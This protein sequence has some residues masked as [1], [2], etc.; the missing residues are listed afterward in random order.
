[1]IF[2]IILNRIIKFNNKYISF[3]LIEHTHIVAQLENNK[4]NEFDN[5]SIDQFHFK[6]SIEN[7]IDLLNNIL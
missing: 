3:E 1:M 7:E 5:K 4:N 2:Q 6:K